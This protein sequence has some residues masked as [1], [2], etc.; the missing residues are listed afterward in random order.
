M[1]DKKCRY[2]EVCSAPLCPKDAKS[3]ESC[4]WFPDE[5]ICRCKQV[6]KWVRTQKSIQ[7]VADK[8]TACQHCFTLPMLMVARKNAI[9]IDPSSKIPIRKQEVGWLKKHSVKRAGKS[10]NTSRI[11]GSNEKKKSTSVITRD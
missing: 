8:D 9:G 5:E 1:A 3:M 10:K 4:T 6:P 2:Y 7:R 11:R